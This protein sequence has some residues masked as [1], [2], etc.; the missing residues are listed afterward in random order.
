G[1]PF[2][3][4]VRELNERWARP[5]FVDSWSQVVIKY[6]ANNVDRVTHAPPSGMYRMAEDGAVSYHRFDTNRRAIDSERE[7]FF[8]RITGAG[9]Y[10]YEGADLG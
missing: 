1:V 4:N 2:E 3:L 6:T 9:D 5:E 7:A 10:R 8:L